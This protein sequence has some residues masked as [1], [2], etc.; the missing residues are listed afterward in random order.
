[1][2]VKRSS[3]PSRLA[4]FHELEHEDEHDYGG[5]GRIQSTISTGV[6]NSTLL[7]KVS[8]IFPGIRMHPWEAG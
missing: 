4:C 3:R 1:M 2:Q 8:A 6:P 7:K 5:A